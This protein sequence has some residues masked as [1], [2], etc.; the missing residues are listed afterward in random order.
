[1]VLVLLE[2]IWIYSVDAGIVAHQLLF[3]LILAPSPLLKFYDTASAQDSGIFLRKQRMFYAYE[4][5]KK[6]LSSPEAT[7]RQFE[8]FLV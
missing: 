3:D 5:V 2:H 4:L 7:W 8:R 1:M 6:A